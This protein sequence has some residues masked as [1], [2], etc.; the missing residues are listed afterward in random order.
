MGGNTKEYKRQYSWGNKY[1][2]R[3][4]KKFLH[5]PKPG[6]IVVRDGVRIR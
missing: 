2:T 6:R 5:P 3:T 4:G 1:S